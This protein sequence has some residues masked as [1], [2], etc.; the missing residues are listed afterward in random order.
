MSVE[1][2]VANNLYHV[3]RTISYC[4]PSKVHMDHEPGLRAM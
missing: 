1:V 2:V 3:S 4:T